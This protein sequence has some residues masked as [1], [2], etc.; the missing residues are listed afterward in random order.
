MAVYAAVRRA[1]AEGAGSG[2][3]WMRS[4]ASPD[5]LVALAAAVLVGLGAGA[6]ADPEAGLKA[7]NVLL[8]AALT[9]AVLAFLPSWIG[10]YTVGSGLVGA[11]Q[12]LLVRRG[13]SGE[14]AEAGGVGA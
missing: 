1:V 4:L 3:L 2:F 13:E 9:L 7:W 6:G 5:G 11:L 12:G 8:P 14:G 10:V